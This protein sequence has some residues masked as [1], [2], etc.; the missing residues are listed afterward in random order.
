MNIIVNGCFGKLGSAVR[1]VIADD[2]GS[3]L[4]AG[5]DLVDA[6]ADFPVY[7]AISGVREKADAMIDCSGAPAL[8]AVLEYAV[9][10]NTPAV[11]CATGYSDAQQKQIDEAARRVQ[12]VCSSNMSVGI[13]L[14]CELAKTCARVLGGSFDV[15]IV[16]AHHNQKLDAPS[17]T[18]VMLADAVKQGLD[19]EAELVYDRHS[20]RE[21][22]GEHEIGMSSIRG[23]TIVG[24]HE[25]IFA[26]RD[27]VVKLS[28]SAFSKEVFAA[29][30]LNAAKF[31]VSVKP[32]RY[33]M[34]DVIG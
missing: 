23:G 27:E 10:T 24:E 14:L 13:N 21:K 12:I 28:H 9:K 15:E 8:T 4:V 6:P 1:R 11:L 19:Y 32:G 29:G 30:A 5:V 16:E 7:N 20:R 33:T 3:V 17:G 18:A 34:K 31:A 2:A 26:G 22:R 25:I